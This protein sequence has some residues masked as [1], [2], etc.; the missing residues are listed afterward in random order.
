MGSDRRN[1]ETTMGTHAEGIMK[2]NGALFCDFCAT[3][4]RVT[5]EHS[6]QKRNL[7]SSRGHP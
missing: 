5:G 2:E 3:N 4:V 1:P 7:I 6:S